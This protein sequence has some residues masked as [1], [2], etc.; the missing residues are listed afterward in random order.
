[1]HYLN[2][3]Y[4]IYGYV[5]NKKEQQRACDASQK[6]GLVNGL[7]NFHYLLADYIL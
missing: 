7:R 4:R 2:N 1:M 3:F 5:V 6:A